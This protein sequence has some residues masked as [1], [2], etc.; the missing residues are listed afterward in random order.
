MNILEGM[1]SRAGDEGRGEVTRRRMIEAAVRV[2]GEHGYYAVGT[3][4]LAEAAG[5]N[6]AAIPYYFGGKDGL[7]AAAAE[8]VAAAGRAAFSPVLARVKAASVESLDRKALAALVSAVF[9]GLTRGLVGPMDTGFRAA[10][11][12]REQL[13]PGPAFDILY[14]GYVRELHEAVTTLVSAARGL[15]PRTAR[16]AIEAH[17]LVGMALAFVVARPTLCRRLDWEDLGT[18]RVNEIEDAVV[19]LALR[20]LGLPESSE[21][22]S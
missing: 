9:T 6:Q 10:F 2:F 7:H 11:I 22:Q 4:E 1:R 3:R 18:R 17:A 15:G 14:R 12:V 8:E 19:G 5:A 20:A 13:Q 16:A 21:V